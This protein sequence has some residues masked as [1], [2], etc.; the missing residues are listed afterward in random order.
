MNK[1]DE[2]EKSGQQAENTNEDMLS[3][4]NMIESVLHEE[5][6]TKKASTDTTFSISLADALK[7]MPQKHL[8]QPLPEISP[9]EKIEITI[10]DLFSQLARGK[11]TLRPDEMAYFIPSHLLLPSAFDDKDTVLSIPLHL[12]VQSLGPEVFAKRTTKTAKVYDVSDI[13]D[14]FNVP[15]V[16]VGT[17]HPATSEVMQE[18]KAEKLESSLPSTS[19]PAEEPTTEKEKILAE[20]VSPM[21]ATPEHG[22]IPTKI[23]SPAET[24]IKEI[25]TTAA[26]TTPKEPVPAI[27]SH[28]EKD[29]IE[30]PGCV[31]VNTATIEELMSISGVTESI[32]REIIAWRED[33]GPFSSIFDLCTALRLSK[34]IFRQITGM[35]YNNKKEHRRA[36]LAALLDVA[37]N[38][39]NDLNLIVE[40]IIKKGSFSGCIISDPDGLILAEKGA[41]QEG[42]T[43]GAIAPKTIRQIIEN[44]QLL[45]LDHIN[46]VSISIKDILY[47]IIPSSTVVLT[48][49]HEEN[50][51]SKSQLVFARK[52]TKEL[53]WLLSRRVYVGH[54]QK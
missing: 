29:F 28:L 19:Q 1:F 6:E 5:E 51:I 7:I 32:G 21:S 31:N 37:P 12:V 39:L 22:E 38:S 16:G 41:E 20:P 42:E 30:F 14:P 47:T 11:V 33:H 9:S 4:I 53:S 17:A 13:A 3:A 8:K 26:T 23:P 15:P 35:S 54:P 43:L 52:V 49:I 2:K 24:V 18:P 48:F 36:K 50:K 10:D 45:S 34:K 27:T 25:Q 44:M 40:N 46:S